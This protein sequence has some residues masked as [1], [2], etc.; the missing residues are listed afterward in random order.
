MV[1]VVCATVGAYCQSRHLSYVMGTTLSLSGVRLSTFRMC[2][3][4]LSLNVIRFFLRQ[5]AFIK[6]MLRAL[7]TRY[8][9]GFGGEVPLQDCN[10]RVG[11]YAPRE[12]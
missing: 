4:Y 7:P 6:V 9:G 5:A 8:K 12:D 3:N 11:D 1:D 2:H 10:H